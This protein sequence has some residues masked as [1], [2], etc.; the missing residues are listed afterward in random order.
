SYPSDFVHFKYLVSV[1]GNTFASNLWWQLLSNSAVLKSES[2]YLEWFYK[3][4]HPYVH[5]VPYEPDL[6]DFK[7]KILWMMEH[8]QEAQLTADQGSAFAKKH[9]TNE[10]LAV[11]FYRLL[12][13]YAKIHPFVEN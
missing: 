10:A 12:Q 7:E 11:Y 2:D 3:G 4:I 13:A 9:L 8:D 6:S 1:D 5:Y